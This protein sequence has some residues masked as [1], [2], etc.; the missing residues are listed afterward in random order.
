M[1]HEQQAKEVSLIRV[2]RARGQRD[3]RR[4]LLLG[5]GFSTKDPP[6][7]AAG[8][9]KRHGL[10]RLRT[11]DRRGAVCG[12]ADGP[13]EDGAVLATLDAADVPCAPRDLHDLV[14]AN[15][16]PV[17]A[18]GVLAER[19][20][21]EIALDRARAFPWQVARDAFKVDAGIEGFRRFLGSDTCILAELRHEA[22]DGVR[23]GG[24]RRAGRDVEAARGARFCL[25]AEDGGGEV[26]CLV[27]LDH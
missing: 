22:P 15:P 26:A 20:P 2:A 8:R 27:V 25:E 13:E 9:R 14:V 1:G 3:L 12:N 6:G 11:H 7:V 16:L 19:D 23:G 24:V 17:S 5:L 10:A 4:G 21:E 18:G